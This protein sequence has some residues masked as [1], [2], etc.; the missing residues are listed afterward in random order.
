M[1]EAPTGKVPV[2]GR[3]VEEKEEE[4]EDLAAMMPDLQARLNAL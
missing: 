3:G 1:E 4:E 2:K